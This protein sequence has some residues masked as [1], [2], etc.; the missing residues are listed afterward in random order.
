MLVIKG[1]HWQTIVGLQRN[2]AANM[3]R[4]WFS[5]STFQM[6]ILYFVGW[7]VLDVTA[8][9]K[10]VDS[11]A[12]SKEQS[13]GSEIPGE[14]WCPCWSFCMYYR[15]SVWVSYCSNTYLRSVG[16]FKL[17]VLPCKSACCSLS[18]STASVTLNRMQDSKV[19]SSFCCATFTWTNSTRS[20]LLTV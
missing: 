17:W 7:L 8:K 1:H 12:V 10:A 4:M 15:V 3:F 9:H 13:F 6:E 2:R 19:F 20:L 16:D 11:D 5:S 18:I 14:L